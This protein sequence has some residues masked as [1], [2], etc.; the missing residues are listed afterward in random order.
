MLLWLQHSDFSTD[1]YQDAT[2]ESAL[3]KFA[4]FDWPGELSQMEQAE[5]QQEECCEPGIGLVRGDTH[6]LH[7][8]PHSA[9]KGSV[10]YHYKKPAKVLGLIPYLSSEDLYAI[11]FPLPKTR[12]LFEAHFL[13]DHARTMAL[14]EPYVAS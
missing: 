12:E 5:N 1:D 9:E 14:L 3:E 6:I 7:L 2:L 8:C 10:F 4:A 13:N 11:D